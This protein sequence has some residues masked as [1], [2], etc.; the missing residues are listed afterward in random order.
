[1]TA[2]ARDFNG[3][4][5]EAPAD[6]GAPRG[7]RHGR[8]M[9]EERVP[10]GRDLCDRLVEMHDL[11]AG[12][13]DGDQVSAEDAALEATERALREEVHLVDEDV[14]RLA[15]VSSVSLP[16]DTQ[17]LRDIGG[18]K[19][20]KQH[21]VS[22]FCGPGLGASFSEGRIGR[23]GRSYSPRPRGRPFQG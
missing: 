20:S 13:R 11:V 18:R 6:A 10:R 1:S 3:A 15:E 2:L 14:P 16:L 22:F 5:R 8:V 7:V 19:P 21:V 17:D 12:G 9:N 23:A 4:L